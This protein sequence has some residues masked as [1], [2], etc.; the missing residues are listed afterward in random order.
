MSGDNGTS[1]AGRDAC[2]GGTT[3]FMLTL[4][5][6]LTV[7]AV[8]GYLKQRARGQ[9]WEKTLHLASKQ[10]DSWEVTGGLQTLQAA[11]ICRDGIRTC[12]IYKR[13]LVLGTLDDREWGSETLRV[14]QHLP[15]SPL[16]AQQHLPSKA[17]PGGPK[18]LH[19]HAD[20][21]M[22]SASFSPKLQDGSQSPL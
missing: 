7:G 5:R 20:M 11:G 22:S 9:E 16:P 10:W 6:N 3:H 18:M 13:D 19:V 1:W 21:S 17:V 4:E 15:P 14:T 12:T 2:D 8:S